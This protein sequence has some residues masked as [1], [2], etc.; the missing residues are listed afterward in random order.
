MQSFTTLLFPSYYTLNNPGPSSPNMSRPAGVYIS[1]TLYP[2]VATTQ[3]QPGMPPTQ[4]R[5]AAHTTSLLYASPT[6]HSNHT[7]LHLVL[8]SAKLDTGWQC[9]LRTRLNWINYPGEVRQICYDAANS[10]ANSLA[11]RHN[12][13]KVTAAELSPRAAH[14]PLTVYTVV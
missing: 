6:C 2:A 9:I 3:Q 4:T 11:T 8:V 10:G 1:N 14:H 13:F 7:V 12:V 5:P